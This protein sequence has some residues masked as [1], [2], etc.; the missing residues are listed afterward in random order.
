MPLVTTT[1]GLA[2]LE[3]ETEW[4]PGVHRQALFVGHGGEVTH[5]QPILCPILKHRA[6]PAVGD[7]LMGN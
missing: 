5:R 1:R 6:V 2:G 3:E 4:V 7:Q